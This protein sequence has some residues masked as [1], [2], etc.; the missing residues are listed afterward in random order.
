MSPCVARAQ[1]ISHWEPAQK[2]QL[3]YI[4][5][6]AGRL[7]HKAAPAFFDLGKFCS[8]LARRISLPLLLCIRLSW[9]IAKGGET[10]VFASSTRC[11]SPGAK[12]RGKDRRSE[13]GTST[14]PSERGF[15]ARMIR[16]FS[17]AT[18]A[19]G[20]RRRRTPSEQVSAAAKAGRPS[21]VP[22][23][24]R[25]PRS[26]RRDRPAAS[27]GR[28][29]PRP[30]RASPRRSPASP[31]HREWRGKALRGRGVPGASPAG[32]GGPL[33]R[34]P[35]PPADARPHPRHRH[36]PAARGGGGG[37]GGPGSEGPRR[38]TGAVGRAKRLS[39][40]GLAPDGGRPGAHA[41]LA[42]AP[43]HRRCQRPGQAR[44]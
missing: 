39:G 2:I 21:R 34:P 16:I 10:I 7:P 37:G 11:C 9:V 31:W 12:H 44:Q 14:S 33:P 32:R 17:I 8:N 30:R 6:T 35:V 19:A 43:P 40:T 13:I 20:E 4:Q 28:R 38:P 22:P 41:P 5:D 36:A 26:G 3:A 24:P 1:V 18:G 27:S 25:R 42:R 29:R 23:P 15:R